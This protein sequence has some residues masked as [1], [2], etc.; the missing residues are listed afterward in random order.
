MLEQPLAVLS[1]RQDQ[2]VE[3]HDRVVQAAELGADVVKVNVPK[4]NPQKD[5]TAPQP[6]STTQFTQ[7]EALRQVVASAGKTLVIFSGGE[8][9]EEGSV[10]EKLVEGLATIF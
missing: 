8:K 7:E 2:D 9:Q 3:A 4:L 10:V 5:A 6:Y 1:R